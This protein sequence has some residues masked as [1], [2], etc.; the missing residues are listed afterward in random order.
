MMVSVT[1]TIT[2]SIVGLVNSK[3]GWKESWP[4]FEVLSQHSPG[5]TWQNL[6]K[7]ESG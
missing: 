7:T 5:G 3:N 1:Q 6:G 2:C 4:H